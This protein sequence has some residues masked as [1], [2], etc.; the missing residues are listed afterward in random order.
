MVADFK[1]RTRRLR[2]KGKSGDL[3]KTGKIPFLEQA[4][5]DYKNLG[6]LPETGKNVGDR[7][8]S[9][10]LYVGG[11]RCV[12]KNIA[13]DEEKRFCQAADY[14]GAWADWTVRADC[15]LCA[16]LVRLLL[17]SYC[18]ENT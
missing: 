6:T 4:P 5:G 18:M 8:R 17:S 14:S 15:F 2:V 16:R 13:E 1:K 9:I 10:F 12:E 11:A 3:Q 7:K